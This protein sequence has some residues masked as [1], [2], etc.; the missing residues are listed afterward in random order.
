MTVKSVERL[1]RHLKEN[2]MKRSFTR[3]IVG[4]LASAFLAGCLTTKPSSADAEKDK[5]DKKD[6]KPLLETLRPTLTEAEKINLAEAIV[7][8][9]LLGI[10][11]DDYS[12]YSGNFFRGLKDQVKEKDFKTLNDDLKKQIGEYK[13][14][15]FMDI[16]NKKLVDIF[17]WKAKFTKTDEDVLI[18]LFLIEE[19]GKYKVSSFS[20]GPF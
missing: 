12:L 10:N 8:K 16:V 17:F 13:S 1:E 18:R 2:K 3:I 4:L 6:E 7:D 9:M 11:K 14:R 5:A 19:E 20:I 15:K